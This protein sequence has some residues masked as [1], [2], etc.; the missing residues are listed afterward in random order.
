MY[1]CFLVS[2]SDNELL[3]IQ[4][5]FS[6]TYKFINT[7]FAGVIKDLDTWEVKYS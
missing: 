7:S 1:G 4:Y 3:P 6:K 2:I 5:R